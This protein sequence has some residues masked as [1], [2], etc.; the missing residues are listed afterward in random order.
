MLNVTNED[1]FQLHKRLSALKI[2]PLF[3]V[4]SFTVKKKKKCFRF[5]R[6]K[7]RVITL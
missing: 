4:V 1:P 6:A 5:Q 7:R 3:C 2:F